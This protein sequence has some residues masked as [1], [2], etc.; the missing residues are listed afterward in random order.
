MDFE[1]LERVWASGANTLSHAAET[2]VMEQT[3]KTLKSRRDG[4][5]FAMGLIGLC[6]TGWTGVMAYTLVFRRV[7]DLSREWSLL[8]MLA[9]PWGLLLLFQAQHR[10]HVRDFPNADQSMPEALAALI[11]ENRVRQARAR[12]MLVT[13]PLFVAVLA[14]VLWQLVQVGKMELRQVAQGGLFFGGVLLASAAVQAVIYFTRTRP[15][16]E[17]LQR[18]LDSYRD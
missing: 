1:S 17:R 3:M 16:G 8:L 12:L 9:V 18:L 15:E 11:D 5:A 10:R 4:F 2:Y 14:L 13:L 7:V 6:L